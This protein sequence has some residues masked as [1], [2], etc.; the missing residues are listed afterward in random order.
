M[1]TKDKKVKRK[2][3]TVRKTENMVVGKVIYKADLATVLDGTFKTKPCVWKIEHVTKKDQEN[4]KSGIWNELN[5]SLDFANKHPQHFMK[6]L[7]Y[8]FGDCSKVQ[9]RTQQPWT[10]AK[11]VQQVKAVES[12][13]ICLHKAYSKMD[14]VLNYVVNNLT[15]KQVYSMFLQLIYAF[16]LLH[17]NNYVHG[18][19]HFGN[20]G[21]LQTS[22]SSKKKLGNVVVPTYGYDWKL[23]DFGMTIHEKDAVT[24]EQKNK[25]LKESDRLTEMMVSFY[26]T[27]IGDD[28]VPIAFI[29]KQMVK[30]DEYKIVQKINSSDKEVQHSLFMTLYPDKYLT[31]L[32]GSGKLIRNHI[33]PTE[34]LIFM[35]H[36]G[37]E[38]DASWDYFLSKVR[39]H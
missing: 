22:S 29:R 1:K 17:K 8:H 32:N 6:L 2:I 4:I 26:S 9:L 20:I 7:H 13:N 38:S 5:F 30:T 31:F 28:D 35:A 39:E 10:H 36:Y 15:L 11:Y 34:D 25:F 3:K 33:L 19:L 27:V 16:K 23:I 12:E 24:K 18:D 14:V 21:A 37:L